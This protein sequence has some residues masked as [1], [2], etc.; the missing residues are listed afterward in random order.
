MVRSFCDNR[1]LCNCFVIVLG[2]IIKVHV[3]SFVLALVECY[4][5]LF[6]LIVTEEVLSILLPV[7]LSC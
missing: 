3:F 1:K 6:C 5:V 2:S 4:F 7:I